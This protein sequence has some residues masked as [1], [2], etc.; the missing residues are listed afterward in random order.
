MRPLN[1]RFP[2]SDLRLIE[3]AE[4]ALAGWSD[5]TIGRKLPKNKTR[6][7]M[8]IRNDSG[9]Q[10]NVQSRRRYGFNFWA[11]DSADAE[12]MALDFE[13]ALRVA[14]DGELI[15]FVDDL[16]GPR[17]IDDDP[18]MTAGNKNL[19]H[20]YSAARISVRGQ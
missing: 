14:A 16:S 11:D 5:L 12:N 1:I 15:T 20:F 19:F 4:A 13:A 17:E 2:S 8:T 9:P 6:R 18:Q 3:I 7:M 10:Q